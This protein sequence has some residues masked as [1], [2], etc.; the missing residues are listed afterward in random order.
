MEHRRLARVTSKG[1][2]TIPVEIRNQRGFMPGDDLV[3][4][5]RNGR[6]FL[7]RPDELDAWL[8]EVDPSSPDAHPELQH[9]A[10]RAQGGRST[11]CSIQ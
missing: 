7:L 6:L 10:R 4:A 5:D 8:A 11:Q 1:R 3:V 2:I 9:T